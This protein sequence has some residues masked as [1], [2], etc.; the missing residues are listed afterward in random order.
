PFSGLS[1]EDILDFDRL[2]REMRKGQDPLLRAL[3]TSL[4]NRFQNTVELLGPGVHWYEGLRSD[5]ILHLNLA[6]MEMDLLEAGGIPEGSLSRE[7]LRHHEWAILNDRGFDGYELLRSNV[8]ILR[9]MFPHLI[10]SR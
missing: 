9:T 5:M 10:R 7:H 3:L 1:Q 6:L 2:I 8:G 4:P